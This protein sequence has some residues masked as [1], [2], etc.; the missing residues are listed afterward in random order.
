MA[1]ECL[2]SPPLAIELAPHSFLPRDVRGIF[3]CFEEG[4]KDEKQ[5]M[6]A[7]AACKNKDFVRKSYLHR[8]K[9]VANYVLSV[10]CLQIVEVS[11]EG[12][13]WKAVRLL[14]SIEMHVNSCSKGCSP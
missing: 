4:K 3:E 12:C 5:S 9:E 13:S 6:K 7:C 2:G 14:I 8:E 10:F 11:W 1:K